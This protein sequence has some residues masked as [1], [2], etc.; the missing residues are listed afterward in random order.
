MIVFHPL[1]SYVFLADLLIKVKNNIIL[2]LANLPVISPA[3]IT[4]L[5]AHHLFIRAWKIDSKNRARRDMK[6]I[7]GA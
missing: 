5:K 1:R 6:K 4:C 7:S 2:T 3:I